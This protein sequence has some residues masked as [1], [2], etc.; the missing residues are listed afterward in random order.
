MYNIKM[1]HITAILLA[2]VALSACAS[3]NEHGRHGGQMHHQHSSG[4]NWVLPALIGAGAVYIATRPDPVQPAQVIVQPGTVIHC[5]PGT[6]P[7]EQRGWVRNQHNQF[8]QSN[9]IECK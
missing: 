3:P 6:M 2:T 8:I 7:F 1:K 5:P 4:G 9:Y